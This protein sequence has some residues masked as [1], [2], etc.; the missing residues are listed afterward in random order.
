[1]SISSALSMISIP[2][3]KLPFYTPGENANIPSVFISYS[4]FSEEHER[5][6]A[7]FA[8][9]LSRL[10]I[11]VTMDINL[12]GDDSFTSFMNKGSL[13]KYVICVCSE[14]YV[15]KV[16]N[17]EKP[18]GSSWEF[19]RIIARSRETL[20]EHFII[21]IHKDSSS[22]PQKKYIPLINDIKHFDFETEEE[23]SIS[24]MIIAWR[25]LEIDQKISNLSFNMPEA[26]EFLIKSQIYTSIQQKLISYWRLEIGS[27]E[28]QSIQR[29]IIS[30]DVYKKDSID[31]KPS[32][33]GNVQLPEERAERIVNL[34]GKWNTSH[35][36]D[37]KAI[38]DLM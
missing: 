14:S 22:D 20:M 23:A 5:W 24:F 35:G 31:E 33:F 27:K 32:S 4:H 6:V 11:S 1:M 3:G 8:Q 28:A 17:R 13:K 9:K 37:I 10:N 2:P 25:I 12:N 15:K 16:L 19:D 26:E 30:G 7:V 36:G 29:A 34:I 18:T 38:T 21:P